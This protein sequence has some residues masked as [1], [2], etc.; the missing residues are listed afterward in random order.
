[1]S[2]IN[3]TPVFV[4]DT[5]FNGLAI[6]R[7]LGSKGIPIYALDTHR[8]IGT[9]SKYVKY[10]HCPDPLTDENEFINFLI[11]LGRNV[12]KKPLLFPTN[13]EWVSAI[14]KN[15]DILENYFLF[16]T[17]D[18]KVN[19]RIINKDL[20][21]EWCQKR[22]YLVPQTYDIK[23]L[24]D[25]TFPIIVKPAHRRLSGNI[26]DSLFF[27]KL[28]RTRIKI[29]TDRK[30]FEIFCNENSE[31]LEHFIFQ[32]YIKG[33]SNCM[34]TVGIYAD[35]NSD[36]LGIFTGHKVRGYPYNYGD[37]VVGESEPLPELVEISK[38][39]IKE[40][41]YT[42][43]AEIEFKKDS[44]SNKFKIIE[45]NPRSWSWIGITPYC[46]VDLPFIAYSDAVLNKK[47]HARS[48]LEKGEV[49]YVHIFD[50]FFNCLFYGYGKNINLYSFFKS[51]S[52][53]VI[54]PEINL[55]DPIPGII[56]FRIAIN[57][58]IVCVIKKIR[59]KTRPVRIR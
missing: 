48:E 53:R 1:M 44:V 21:Y 7:S 31:I 57:G 30:D 39:L 14:S 9:F 43:V 56:A 37:C 54:S 41:N 58:C 34:Y 11:N 3:K 27:K 4:F 35:K 23:N 13:D 33:N 36:L 52:K 17:S 20:F 32:E 5:H 40:L 55:R 6:I 59:Q 45:I 22:N 10:I 24:D 12:D 16:I 29:I 50:D 47:L 51:F 18:W 42:G 49:R 28:G 26:E 25:A 8:S 19:K 15:K 2:H 38:K 46:G